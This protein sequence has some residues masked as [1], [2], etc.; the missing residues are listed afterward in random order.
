MYSKLRRTLAIAALLAVPTWLSAQENRVT[1]QVTAED[2]GQPLAGVQIVVKGTTVGTLSDGNG[3]F[4]VRVPAGSGEL[5]FSY[6]GYRTMER[7]ITGPV[8]NVTMSR[9]AIGLEGITVTALGIQREKRSLGY[10]VQD[11]SA[12]QI[13]EVP[14]LNVVDALHGNVA[15]VHI[16]N[17]A[18]PGGASRI[19]IRGASSING[20]NQP[21]FVVDGIPIDNSSSSNN[22]SSNATGGGY[23]YANRA[24]D[25]DPNNIESISVLKGPNAAA[26]YGSRAAN[27]AVVITTK[28]GYHGA[29]LGISAT[30]STMFD[31][32]LRLPDYQNKYGQGSSGQFEWVDGNWGGVADGMDE[33]WGPALSCDTLV[34]QFSG[35][36]QPWCPHPN[37][38]R[39]FFETGVTVNT[40]VAIARS[41]ERSNVRLSVTNMQQNGMYPNNEINRL[42]ASLAGGLDV[43]DRMR[44]E[45]AIDYMK[46]DVANLPATGYTGTNV[47]QQFIWF[48]RQVDVASL[49]NYKC[50]A[51]DTRPGCVL[52]NDYYNWNYSY[53]DNP[54]V[55]AYENTNDAVTDHV[56]GHALLS[57][58]F[59]DWLTAT[60]RSGTDWYQESRQRNYAWGTYG[61]ENPRGAFAHDEIFNRE[62]NTDFLVTGTRNLTSDLSLTVNAGG[63][64]RDQEYHLSNYGASELVVPGIYTLDNAGVTPSTN[65]VIQKKRV[66]SLYGAATLNFRNYLNLDVTGRNDWSSTLPEANNSYFY[67]SVSG[68]F[69]FTDAFGIESSLLSSG[70]LRASWTRVGND[71]DPY[72]LLATFTSNDPFGGL[73]LFSVPNTLPNATLKPEETTAWEVGTDLGFLNERVGFVLTYYDNTTINQIMPVQISATSGY[74]NQVLNA[75]EVRNWGYELLANL[76]PVKQPNGLRWD[77]TVNWAKNNSEVV[78]LY[79]DLQT[80]VL[81]TYWG[82]NVEARKGE[83]YGALFGTP[84]LREDLDGDGVGDP[85]GRVIV[86]AG[87]G[88]PL[89]D[90]AHR[91]VLGNYNPDWTGGLLNRFTYKSFD[92]S[93]LFDM[94]HGGDVY[95]VTNMF[96][97]YSGVLEGS[98]LGRENGPC[99][100]GIVVPHSAYYDA[101]GNLV[102]NSGANAVAACPQDYF[103]GSYPGHEPYIHDASYVKLRELKL[104]V[105]LPNSWVTKLGF[106]SADIALIGRNLAL[107]TDMPNIDPETAFSA[108]NVQGLEFG[109]FPTARSIG[110]TVTVR[111]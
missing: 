10:S 54:Y 27:G 94:Q 68:A 84:L 18:G 97:E 32:P 16:T 60:V 107:W 110:F 22:G 9:E 91:R 100:P 78:D 88:V 81:G 67:P 101:N 73:P 99:D 25:L 64:R 36:N 57:Y 15:G 62:T 13:S 33:S 46:N 4:A 79:G 75:G 71:A 12:E 23:N 66:N 35:K 19:V 42:G 24:G 59:T 47:M 55:E 56:L 83:P 37:N 109:Q 45:G 29:G 14:K 86:S 69:V 52:G 87:S 65:D 96:G 74:R 58:D 43:T 93:V 39:D 41:D 106:G 102:D 70:K 95:S 108:G 2:S 98:L 7:E 77:M 26:L 34:D 48:G 89:Q 85:E 76:T 51:G 61:G 104:G 92:L 5:V 31:T 38:V 72:Q 8:V 53:H 49:S 6:L 105:R 1:G 63:N 20:N 44:A 40:N 21:L 82:L 28:K 17:T 3:N 30:V 90:A 103:E 11:V 50:V 111:P 80:L